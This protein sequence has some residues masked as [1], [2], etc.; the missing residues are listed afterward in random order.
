MKNAHLIAWALS[1]PWALM[2]ER[3]A[4]YAG[5]L[6]SH[7]A[8]SLPPASQPGPEAA[9][10]SSARQSSRAGNIA[11]INVFGA[12]V[13]W[14]G[15]ID[16]C[17]GG[18]SARVVAQQLTD[19]ENDETVGQVLMVYN[20]PGGS[21]YG[22]AELGDVI[23]RVKASKPVIGVAQSLA[24]SAGYWALSQCTEA[25]CTPGGEVGSIGVYSGYQN[26][27]KAMEMAG[28]DIQLFS[29]GKYK[30]EMSPFSD[31]LSPEA[32]AYQEQRA[33][34]YYAM[35]T[36]AVAKGRNVPIDAVRNGMG[37]G[38]VLGADAALEAGMIDGV[39][40]V[41]QVIRKMQR[42]AKAAR[43]PGRSAQANRNEIDLLSI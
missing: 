24:A 29:A 1:H 23:N 19:A 28:V 27:A 7:Y 8:G 37:Q 31:G 18:A 3:M 35:F 20:T 21:V 14:P 13:E 16:V 32:V 30:T 38:R 2:P 4:A 11:V 43:S 33:Q 6:A 22:T 40:N 12:M 41:D 26:I 17:E 9:S 34:D 5:V 42:D 36:K 25:Y 15:D 39:M 10:Q